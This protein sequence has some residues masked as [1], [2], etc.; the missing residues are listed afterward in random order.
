MNCGPEEREK[1]DALDDDAARLV[2]ALD[3]LMEGE[4]VVTALVALGASAI[5]P[6]RRFL[7]EAVRAPSINL[8]DGR[9]RPWVG[10]TPEM[11]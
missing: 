10:W 11:C 9:C 4:G 8:A 3:N 1:H 5:G 6:L 7:L 2:A